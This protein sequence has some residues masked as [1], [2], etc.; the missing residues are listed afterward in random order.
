MGNVSFG[1]TEG[2][3][4]DHDERPPGRPNPWGSWVEFK[5]LITV[6]HG[7]EE[8]VMSHLIERSHHLTDGLITSYERA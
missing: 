7:V 1:E 5:S 6:A 3:T 8:N 4:V 2:M